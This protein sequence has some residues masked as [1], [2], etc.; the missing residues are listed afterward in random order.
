MEGF[1][2]NGH[3]ERSQGR[4]QGGHQPKKA[5]GPGK[6]VHSDAHGLT[7]KMWRNTVLK[8]DNKQECI[9]TPISRSNNTPS[10]L[11]SSATSSTL[12]TTTSTIARTS[13]GNE[14]GQTSET[15]SPLT[16]LDFRDLEKVEENVSRKIN[17]VM[18][19]SDD[20]DIDVGA[21]ENDYEL[22]DKEV[23]SVLLGLTEN[24]ALD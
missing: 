22:L 20:E 19:N 18:V 4:K 12:S 9:N 11:D 1:G 23:M 10:T 15:P 21:E 16:M 17:V 7:E 5:R 14:Q 8:I 2:Q 6:W 13:P 24:M 3:R